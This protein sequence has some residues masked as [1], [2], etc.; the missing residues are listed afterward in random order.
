MGLFFVL[1]LFIFVLFEIMEFSIA[2]KIKE[3]NAQLTLADAETYT[4]L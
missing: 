4:I 2:K 1:F 3:F